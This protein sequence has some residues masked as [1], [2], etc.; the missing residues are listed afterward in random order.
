MSF[1]FEILNIFLLSIGICDQSHF[2]SDRERFLIALI[3]TQTLSIA[4][5]IVLIITKLKSIINHMILDI[6]P[7]VLIIYEMLEHTD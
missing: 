3:T 7:L 4:I 2:F 6:D 1:Q 5:K